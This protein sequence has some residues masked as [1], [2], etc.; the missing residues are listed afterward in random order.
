[1]KNPFETLIIPGG[2][3]LLGFLSALLLPAPQFGVT[4]ARQ[5]Q[6]NLHLQDVNQLYTIVFCLWFL[7]LGAI[8][9]FVI[10]FAWR[11]WS[12]A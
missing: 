11:L 5:L 2:I 3:L 4:L 12:K 6:E 7:I 10:R 8:E 9:F 1:M